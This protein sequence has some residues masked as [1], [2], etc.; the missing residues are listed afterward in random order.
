MNKRKTISRDLITPDEL[1]AWLKVNPRWI[2]RHIES[3]DL[4]PIKVGRL[5]RFDPRDIEAL[6]ER[7]SPG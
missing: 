7:M 3:G 5:N 2:A 4:K 1:M 6:L